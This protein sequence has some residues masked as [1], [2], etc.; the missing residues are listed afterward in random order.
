[1]NVCA[2]VRAVNG[3]SANTRLKFIHDGR[4]R[5]S[6]LIHDKHVATVVLSHV[7]GKLAP[8]HARPHVFGGAAVLVFV[9][10][11]TKLELCLGLGIVLPRLR[12]GISLG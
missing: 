9:L 6:S 2:D 10:L 12:L 7:D 5:R 3:E 11:R 1:M 8:K 4:E